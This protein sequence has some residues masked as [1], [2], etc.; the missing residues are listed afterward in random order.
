MQTQPL[1]DRL[2]QMT[3]E[4]AKRLPAGMR[5]KFSQGIEDVRATG[6]LDKALKV[7]DRLPDATL[8]GPD[9]EVSVGS[10]W[11][12]RPLVVTFYRGGWCPYCNTALQALEAAREEIEAAGASIVAVAPE[13]PEKTEQTA[14]ANDLSLTL[15]TDRG[16]RFAGKLGIAFR[17]PD[18]ILPIYRDRVGLAAFNGDQEFTLP[19]AATYVVDTEGVIRWAFLDADYKK[20]AEPAD[21]VAAV[22]KLRGSAVDTMGFTTLEPSIPHRQLTREAGVWDAEMTMWAS[23]GAPAMTATAVETNRMLGPFWMVSN[24]VC[25]SPEFPFSGHMQ[26]GYD[27]AEEKFIATW[28][29]TLSPHIVRS[30]GT[31][32]I[33]TR[34]LTLIGRGVDIQTGK[35]CVTTMITQYVDQNNKL[36]TIY[37]GDR[38]AEGRKTMEIKYSRRR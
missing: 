37:E 31:Y 10:L 23:P 21:V 33:A 11:A 25:E 12:D 18:V 2:N 15:L 28:V 35:P 7:G 24:F 3:A 22:K 13:L 20:R 34:S 17:L 29:D 8:Q 9:G 19:L 32:D 26:L 1:Q 6:I 36:F 38:G 27:K 5:S 30:E 16:N 4:S 14:A